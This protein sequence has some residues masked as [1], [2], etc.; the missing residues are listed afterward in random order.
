M[1]FARCTKPT[2]SVLNGQYQD[3]YN[4]NQNQMKNT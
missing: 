2:P 1:N 3:G 4:T